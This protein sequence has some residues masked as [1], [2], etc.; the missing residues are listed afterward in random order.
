MNP[1]IMHSASRNSLYILKVITNLFIGLKE[2]FNF[3]REDPREYSLIEKKTLKELG[4]KAL[5]DWKIK[6]TRETLMP[7]RVA[8]HEKMK[9]LELRRLAREDVGPVADS[10]VEVHREIV[11]GL[12]WKKPEQVMTA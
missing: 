4:V 8:I 10:G 2:P 9:E 3:N 5:P 11:K 1:L 7:G 12:V 6:G